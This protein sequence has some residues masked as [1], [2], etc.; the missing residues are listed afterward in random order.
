MLHR[1]SIQ[2]LRQPGEV[3]PGN[4]VGTMPCTLLSHGYVSIIAEGSNSTYSI[5]SADAG[6]SSV[7]ATTQCFRLCMAR[8]LAAATASILRSTKSSGFREPNKARR[9]T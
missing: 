2:H 3:V 5:I 9:G 7:L 6:M 8:A 4:R 1:P